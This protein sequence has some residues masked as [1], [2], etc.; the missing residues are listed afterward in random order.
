[1][2]IIIESKQDDGSWVSITDLTER[3]LEAAPEA[4]VRK[5]KG[6]VSGVEVNDGAAV[7]YLMTR[8]TA[9]GNARKGGYDG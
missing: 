6:T 5:V 3:V 4:T 9:K 8:Y 1:V 2:A 7:K